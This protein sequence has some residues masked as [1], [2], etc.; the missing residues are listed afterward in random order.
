MKH[1]IIAPQA[2]IGE[3]IKALEK[4]VKGIVLVCNESQQL[5]GTITDGDIRRAILRGLGLDAPIQAILDFKQAAG[6]GTPV[7]ASARADQRVL[8]RL[9]RQRM[10][11]QVP[12]LDEQNRVVSLV[13]WDDLLPDTA[14]MQ[15]VVM[16]GG[17][18][19]RLQPLTNDVPKP[20][21]PVGEKPLLEHIL[22]QLK[23][24]GIG[25]V[26]ISTHYLPEKITDHFKD[27]AEFGL[28]LN[29]LQESEPSGTAGALRLLPKPASP[30]L[31]INGDILTKVDFQSMRRYH[32]EHKAAATVGVR[33]YEFR[34]PYAIINQRNGFAESI[35]EKPTFEFFANAGIYILEPGVLA[36]IPAEGRFDMP[37]L[38]QSLLDTGQPVAIFPIHEYWLDIGRWDD[39]LKAQADFA[40]EKTTNPT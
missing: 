21:L 26:S 9:M 34:V 35:S 13:T 36:A 10:V 20:M 11:R 14:D 32:Q 25:E 15:A 12:L 30:L 2:V 5:L 18:G 27:G 31:V 38:I 23:D 22:K 6:Y 1:C 33:Q 37:D 4:N 19:K 40:A 16:A 39:Y 28:N 24:A 17:L 8:I 29:Y 7:T 3:A